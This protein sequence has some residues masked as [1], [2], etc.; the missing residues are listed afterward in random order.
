MSGLPRPR[1]AVYRVANHDIPRNVETN[2]QLVPEIMIRIS[3]GQVGSLIR[4]ILSV[5]NLLDTD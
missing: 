1:T 4:G 2:M 3:T 5:S